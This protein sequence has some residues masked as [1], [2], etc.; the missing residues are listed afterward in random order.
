MKHSIDAIRIYRLSYWL[1]S[2]GMYFLA[3]MV[4]RLNLLIFNCVIPPS[5]KIGKGTWLAHSVGIVLH[6]YCEIGENCCICQNVTLGG[7][8][9]KIGNNCLIGANAVCLG[10]ITI[11][12]N[13][14]I[15]ANTFVN[16]N[17]SDGC[18]VVGTKGHILSH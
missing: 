7:G 8:K 18:T 16:F 10:E 14:R 1:N 4:Y 17:V 6:P 5:C 11:G 3:G 13:C 2:H 12:N 9:I 15:G